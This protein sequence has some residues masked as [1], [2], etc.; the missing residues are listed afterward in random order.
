LAVCNGT[1]LTAT[2][3]QVDTLRIGGAPLTPPAASAVPEPS[4]FVLLALA[5]MTVAWF[6]VRK[7]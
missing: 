6:A 1:S 7:R 3:I 2:S 4:S 5:G